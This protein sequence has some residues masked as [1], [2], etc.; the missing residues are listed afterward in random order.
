M[1]FLA[2]LLGISMFLTDLFF[3]NSFRE[4]FEIYF[5]LIK[6]VTISLTISISLFGLAHFLPDKTKEPPAIGPNDNETGTGTA[7]DK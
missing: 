3:R 5:N 7:T 6:T 1:I 2:S 4:T